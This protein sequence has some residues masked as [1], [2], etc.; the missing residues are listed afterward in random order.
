MIQ[1]AASYCEAHRLS[2]EIYSLDKYIAILG[3]QKQVL[4]SVGCPCNIEGI[5]PLGVAE[6]GGFNITISISGLDTTVPAAEGLKCLINDKLE[7]SAVPVTKGSIICNVPALNAIP[8]MASMQRTARNS[9][10]N[11]NSSSNSSSVVNEN[12]SSVGY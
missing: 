11:P 4:M 6:E 2:E 3:T 1:L 5:Y 10:A 12:P 7:I 9:S 8:G